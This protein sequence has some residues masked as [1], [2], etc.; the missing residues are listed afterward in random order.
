MRDVCVPVGVDLG[1]I[2]SFS[3]SFFERERGGGG[4]GAEEC[5]LD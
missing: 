1:V 5:A 3:L 2:F 4:G